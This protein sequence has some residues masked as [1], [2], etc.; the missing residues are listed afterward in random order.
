MT[1]D[2]IRCLLHNLPDGDSEIYFHP[3][4]RRDVVLDRL[5]PTYEHEAEFAALLDKGLLDRRL[6]DMGLV[7]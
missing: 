7:G 5:M 2:R 3:A 4:T 6:L 1:A